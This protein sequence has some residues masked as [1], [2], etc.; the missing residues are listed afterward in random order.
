M[1]YIQAS[2]W[3]LLILHFIYNH[4]MRDKGGK[5][6]IWVELCYVINEWPLIEA[7]KTVSSTSTSCLFLKQDPIAMCWN[8]SKHI[9]QKVLRSI[10]TN[11][12]LWNG[13]FY[14]FENNKVCKKAKTYEGCEGYDEDDELG[15]VPTALPHFEAIVTHSW[16]RKWL[17]WTKKCGHDFT[18][19]ILFVVNLKHFS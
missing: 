17:N 18:R 14:C 3:V 16:G 6:Q 11:T 7:G 19:Q 1:L 2:S 8:E 10:M 5:G 9:G 12:I 15:E 4:D 13:N